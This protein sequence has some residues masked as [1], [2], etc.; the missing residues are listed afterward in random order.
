M[1]DPR[2]SNRR[3]G[4]V[5]E[6]PKTTV[7]RLAAERLYWFADVPAVT[8]IPACRRF[9]GQHIE[10]ALSSDRNSALRAEIGR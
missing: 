5:N 9:A 1:A 10:V 6:Q 2:E 7:G 4:F 8:A 3:L